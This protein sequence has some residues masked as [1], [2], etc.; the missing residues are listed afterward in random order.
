MDVA[1]AKYLEA[2]Y[3]GKWI[4]T[5]SE[6]ELMAFRI[7][8]SPVSVEIGFALRLRNNLEIEIFSGN[9]RIRSDHRILLELKKRKRIEVCL[10]I[11]MFRVNI[12]KN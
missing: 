9:R 3:S 12:L 6:N 8:I 2:E 10:F 4:V 7:D 11:I 5:S 1:V